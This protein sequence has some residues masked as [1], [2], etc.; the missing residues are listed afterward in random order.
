MYTFIYIL[1]GF[2]VLIA[3]LALIAPKEYNVSRTIEI[4]GTKELIFPHLQYLV[5]QRSWSPW[6]K[7]DK[8]METKLIGIDGTV[9]AIS[10][11]K[12]NRD[13]GEGEQEL[14]KIIDGERVEGK[15]RFLKPWKSQSDCY[16]TLLED[17]TH[18]CKVTWGFSGRNKFPF[19]IV[20]LFI[21]MDK[22]VGKDFE[23][24]LQNLKTIIEG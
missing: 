10:H 9:G 20:T 24:G 11:W 17:S 14:T 23:E 3:L 15:L 5:K 19:S 21:G 18:K 6:M 22:M 12:G 1:V 16:L 8:N 4:N 7:K 2:L 13:V